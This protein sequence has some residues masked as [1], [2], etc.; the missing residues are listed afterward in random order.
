MDMGK[1]FIIK[2]TMELYD[3]FKIKGSKTTPAYPQCNSQA[4]VFNK[5]LAKYMKTVVDEATTQL[6][7]QP[8][9]TYSTA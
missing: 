8:H 4:E 9:S 6:L 5:T 1:E 2:I 7:R 3:K